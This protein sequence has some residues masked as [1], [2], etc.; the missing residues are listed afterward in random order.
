M[1]IAGAGALGEDGRSSFVARG[2]TI[3]AIRDDF[4]ERDPMYLKMAKRFLLE[5]DKRLAWKFFR[6]MGVGGVR[7]VLK[8]RRRLKR[9]EFFP[10]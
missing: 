3:E 8:Y 5:T 9:G 2:V 1:S 7:S 6:I 4:A 10:P